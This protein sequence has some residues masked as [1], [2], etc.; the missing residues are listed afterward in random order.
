MGLRLITSIYI[1]QTI[2]HSHPSVSQIVKEMT[3]KRLATTEKDPNDARVSVVKL[4]EAGHQL[5]P[6]LEKQC[7]DVT[8]AVEQLLSES[9]YDFWKASKQVEFLLGAEF[10]LL[11]KPRKTSTKMRAIF[12]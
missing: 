6:S 9:Q 12:I 3:K 8:Q 10:S 2:G 7:I 11:R 5:V 1:A 4:S